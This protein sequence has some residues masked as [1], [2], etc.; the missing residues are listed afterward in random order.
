MDTLSQLLEWPAVYSQRRICLHHTHW[1]KG[2][3][4]PAGCFDLTGLHSMPV[5][6]DPSCAISVTSCS[7]PR[8]AATI[9]RSSLDA[10]KQLAA[11]RAPSVTRQSGPNGCCITSPLFH[12]LLT[13][14]T[15]PPTDS[16]RTSGSR[17]HLTVWFGWHCAFIPL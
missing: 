4:A 11:Q 9:M 8:L 10:E 17:D 7:D 3:P 16:L 14:F 15:W 2:I 12:V 5:L 6:C 13:S 1:G